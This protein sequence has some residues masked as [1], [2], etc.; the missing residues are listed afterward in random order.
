MI[1]DKV[2]KNVNR[3]LMSVKDLFIKTS[4]QLRGAVV[5]SVVNLV[6][7]IKAFHNFLKILF[8]GTYLSIL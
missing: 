3:A 2:L 7:Q 6:E 5:D 4:P 1:P 8:Q